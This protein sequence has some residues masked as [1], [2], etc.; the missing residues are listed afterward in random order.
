MFLL[1]CSN[2]VADP[3]DHGGAAG[4]EGLAEDYPRED[5]DFVPKYEG[6]TEEA[7]PE[8]LELVS[9]EPPF[10]IGEIDADFIADISCGDYPDTVFD[11]F[12]PNVEN[13]TPLIIYFH[14]G[15]FTDGDKTAAWEYRQKQVLEAL[16]NGIAFAS[17]NYRLLDEVDS[18]GV[19]KPLKD[20]ARCLQ[21]TRYH[22]DALNIDPEKIGLMGTSAGAGTSLWLAFHDDLADSEARDPI[23]REST[24]VKA[25][26]VFETQGTYDIVKWSTEVFV[27]YGFDLLEVATALGLEQ[28]LLSFYGITD[29]EE[30]HSPEVVAYRADVD[31]LELMTVDDA[32][33]WVQNSEFPNS[34]PLSVDVAF[35]HPNHAKVLYDRAISVGLENVSYIPELDI[36]HPSGEAATDFLIRH[37][38]D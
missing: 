13:S 16:R 28:L 30:I 24:R 2:D 35:H 25:A 38:I 22:S 20:S 12:L 32:P 8:I 19:H 36:N 33:F 34:P 1:A 31:M 18:T 15:G 3:L 17:V 14:G 21:F 5:D 11:I 27:D 29:V 7:N 37:F 26:A 10:E 9:V 23:S 4:D 6:D